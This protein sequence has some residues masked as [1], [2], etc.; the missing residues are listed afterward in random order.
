MRKLDWAE[1]KQQ[2]G[3]LKLEAN[4]ALFPTILA[5]PFLQPSPPWP[6]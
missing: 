1:A 2:M 3:K 4:P 5:G 6:A